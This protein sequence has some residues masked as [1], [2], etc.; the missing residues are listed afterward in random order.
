MNCAYPH[1]ECAL[2]YLGTGHFWSRCAVLTWDERFFSHEDDGRLSQPVP[3]TAAE[4]PV[5]MSTQF[6]TTIH[7]MYRKLHICD[8][9]HL[10]KQ[11]CKENK[12]QLLNPHHL[13]KPNWKPSSSH[14]I[15]ILISVPS[16]CYSHSVCVCVCTLY[17]NCFG[18]TMLY[19]YRE[20]HI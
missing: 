9:S 20:Y 15:S 4:S 6:Q 1:C 19:M 17:V 12:D 10:T 13:L 2:H 14:S 3:L 16:F 11:L 18:R 8:F 5:W 7:F